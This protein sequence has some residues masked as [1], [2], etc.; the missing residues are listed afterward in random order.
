MTVSDENR[1]CRVLLVDD[2]ESYRS[3]LSKLL[4]REKDILV[5]GEAADGR[6]ALELAHKLHP[7]VIIMDVMMTPSP[8]HRRHS[9]DRDVGWSFCGP[10]SPLPADRGWADAARIWTGVAHG[11][12]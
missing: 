2:S 5:V 9:T 8:N 1:V 3:A 10:L 4:S 12:K 11:L 6:A 7:D